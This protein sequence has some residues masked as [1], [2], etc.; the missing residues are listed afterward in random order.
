MNLS[1]TVILLIESIQCRV[2]FDDGFFLDLLN[3]KT[4][5]PGSN[6]CCQGTLVRFLIP[7]NL[8]TW[9]KGLLG[10]ECCRGRVSLKDTGLRF[11]PPNFTSQHLSDIGPAAYLF[12]VPIPHLKI[13]VLVSQLCPTLWDPM[14][15]SP[16][17][18]SVRGILQAR[19][20]EW[21]AIPSS[22]G[23]SWLGDQTPVSALQ[24][25]SLQLEPPGRSHFFI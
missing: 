9:L 5:G 15:W 22:R 12:W 18:S 16:P 10:E 7:L 4:Q 23:S 25:D 8:E 14:D 21:A 24:A 11:W 17:G 20:L 6:T 19:I 1:V 13:K 2:S 3:V